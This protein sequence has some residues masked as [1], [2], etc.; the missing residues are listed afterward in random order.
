[1]L[2][3]RWWDGWIGKLHL[4]NKLPEED[5]L[6]VILGPV[7]CGGWHDNSSFYFSWR[8]AVG[9]RG[10]VGGRGVLDIFHKYIQEMIYW[11]CRNWYSSMLKVF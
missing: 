2:V 10:K 1:M 9:V 7:N 5:G 6:V 4:A 3:F 8:E 11:G